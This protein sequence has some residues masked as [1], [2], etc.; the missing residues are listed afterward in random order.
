MDLVDTDEPQLSRHE[1]RTEVLD[2]LL[3][4][5]EIGALKVT[6]AQRI[7]RYYLTSSARPGQHM[8]TRA[9]GQEGALLRQHASR[10]V[11]SLRRK[12]DLG[13][14]FAAA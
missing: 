2:L 4:A 11:R 6:E 9:M 3:W 8:T 14:Y 5:V 1:A 10:A 7:A 13:Q 12:A